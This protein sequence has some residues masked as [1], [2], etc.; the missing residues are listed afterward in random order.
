MVKTNKQSAVP[1][2]HLRNNNMVGKKFTIYKSS[3]FE[4]SFCTVVIR[5][6]FIRPEYYNNTSSSVQWSFILYIKK[7]VSMHT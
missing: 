4:P 7:K 6:D 5:Q 1:L 3:D 2:F